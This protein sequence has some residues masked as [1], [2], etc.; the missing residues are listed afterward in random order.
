MKLTDATV[1]KLTMP[2][3]RTEHFEWDDSLPGF[4]VRA[5]QET[6]Q[7]PLSKRWYV[8]Y[9]VG[10]QQRRESL[11]DVRKVGIEAARKIAKQRFAMAE[12]GVDPAAKRAQAKAE[13][14]A[15]KLKFG[16]VAD[17]YLA[18][19]QGTLRPKSYEAAERY[20]QKHW[21][22]LRST[23]LGK[24]QRAEVAV[25][26]QEITVAHGR[27]SAA[28]A[29]SNLSAM[30]SWAMKEGL[31]ES[32]PV[33]AT[34]DPA[35]GIQPRER[36]LSDDEIR[37]IWECLL[38]DSFGKIVKLLL[39]CGC[40]REEIGALKWSEIDFD[41]GCLTIP[42]ARTKSHK[43]LTLTLAPLAIEILKSVPRHDGQEFVFG[44]A[45]RA[46]F[47]AWSYCTIA[48]NNRI[49]ARCG[50]PLPRFVLHDLRRTMRSG[51]SKLDVAPHVAE[52]AIGHAVQ[53]VKKIYDLYKYEPKIEAALAAWAA[54][55]TAIV[56][57]RDEDG[58]KVV[59]L[60]A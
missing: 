16:A 19:K 9:R 10:H 18:I 52:L 12:N 59:M 42:G 7:A 21:K 54:H 29:R 24:V 43:T 55:V 58:D 41:S 22:G 4:G 26:L 23:P 32:N 3:G 15:Q 2:V 57:G 33:I 14:E 37:I 35:S 17:R 31:C 36:I 6:A 44:K 5:R 8:Q 27:V 48:L 39:L 25:I 53:G 60:R 40:R 20:L 30:F 34:N 51:L 38:D 1:A 13:A 46:G 56:E 28:R 49:A 45:G 47:N 50:R 11:G